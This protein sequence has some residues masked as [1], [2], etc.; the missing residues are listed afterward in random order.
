[1]P[2]YCRE[3]VECMLVNSPTDLRGKHHYYLYL[4]GK[5]TGE[6]FPYDPAVKTLPSSARGAGLIPGQGATCFLAKK[7]KHKTEA[8]P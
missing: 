7:P 1:M 2:Y 5:N 3:P 4:S 6:D 8:M